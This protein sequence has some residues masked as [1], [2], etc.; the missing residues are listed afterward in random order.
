VCGGG[1]VRVFIVV[2]CYQ[3]VFMES[4]KRKG[5]YNLSYV[6]QPK[7]Y[8][9]ICLSEKPSPGDRLSSCLGG[10]KARL[11]YLLQKPDKMELWHALV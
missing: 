8:L 1:A 6:I 10:L 9:S 2:A 4:K 5:F 7:A 3:P 11:R